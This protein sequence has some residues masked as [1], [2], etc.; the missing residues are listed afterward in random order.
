MATFDCRFSFNS[1]ISSVDVCVVCVCMRVCVCARV[2][3]SFDKDTLFFSLAHC[4]MILLFVFQTRCIASL[5]ICL[6]LVFFSLS[7]CWS[8]LVVCSKFWLIWWKCSNVFL[9]IYGLC[10]NVFLHGR[11]P[12]FIPFSIIYSTICLVLFPMSRCENYSLFP[13]E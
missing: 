11:S 12:A 10:L 1:I 3:F 6:L 4:I 8:N 13:V 5:W 2:C 9:C 7:V